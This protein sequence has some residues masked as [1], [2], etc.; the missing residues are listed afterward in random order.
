M[1]RKLGLLLPLSS[2]F[3]LSYLLPP[4]SS[5]SAAFA[6]GATLKDVPPFPQGTVLFESERKFGE[7][8]RFGGYAM[9]PSKYGVFP[10][11]KMKRPGSSSDP[12]YIRYRKEK[13]PSF[14]G[15]YVLVLGDLSRYATLTFW[16]K[17]AKGGET[18][19]IGINDV[20]SNKR[21]DAVIIG[22]IYRYLSAGVT[23]EWQQ[24]KIPLEVFF[25][26]D[27]NRIYS[28][29]FNFNEQGEGIFWIDGLEFHEEAMVHSEDAITAQGALL[30]DN[31]DH[32]DVNLLGRKAN[33]YKRLPSVCE[34]TRAEEPRRGSH[35]R[36]L[37]L[38]YDKKS[39]GWCGY[40]SLLNQIDGA[41]F[42]LNPYKEVS[43][44]VRGAKGGEMFEVGM[45]DRSWLTIGDS[46]KAGAVDKYLPQGVTTDWQEVVIPLSDFGKL[47]W[48]QMGSFTI[49]FHQAGAGTLFVEDLR[50]IRKSDQ[51]LLK[52]WD[53]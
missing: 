16:I 37:Q 35:G 2:L 25:G 15:A 28:I 1:K 50:F 22:S 33:A 43:F 26:T 41:Y 23:T 49:N 24:V 45:A 52:E 38:D 6:E 31:F 13:N 17:G 53:Q 11:G 39:T 44:W 46:V 18:F 20:I 51:D 5:L 12:I 48:G 3:F 10:D 4:I 29:V 47:D 32:S 7:R 34:F 42:D 40:Y 8:G 27:L 19:E 30:L 36:S 14:C 21:E 9:K